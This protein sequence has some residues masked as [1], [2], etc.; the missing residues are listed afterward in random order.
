MATV[1]LAAILGATAWSG[2]LPAIGLAYFLPHIATKHRL[3]AFAYYAAATW[4][5][6]P[7]AKAFLPTTTP[8]TV[9]I[10]LTASAILALPWLVFPRYLALASTAITGIASPFIAAGV[11]FPGTAWLGLIASALPIRFALPIALAANALH[12]SIPPPKD[13]TAIDTTRDPESAARASTTKFTVFPENTVHNWTEATELFWQ[14]T[15]DQLKSEGRTILLGVTIPDGPTTWNAAIT[16]GAG[17]TAIYRQR[18]PVPTGH[19]PFRPL[20]PATN[21]IGEQKAAILICFEQ[22]LIWPMLS[23]MADMPNVAIGIANAR[24]TRRTPVPAVQ[25]SCLQAWGRLFRIPI[26]SATDK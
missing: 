11:L 22:L 26:V 19:L 1:I 24:W 12:T 4:P 21:Q 5:T 17:Q 20:G 16:L 14:P 3:A 6:I 15:I 7:A 23:G 25:Q 13:W 8:K 18:I 9:A 10:W 2:P